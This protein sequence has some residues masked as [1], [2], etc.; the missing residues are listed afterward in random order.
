MISRGS[1]GRRRKSG[2]DNRHPQRQRAKDVKAP[3]RPGVG[4]SNLSVGAASIFP[5]PD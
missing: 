3:H 4:Q 2:A 5:K 1:E